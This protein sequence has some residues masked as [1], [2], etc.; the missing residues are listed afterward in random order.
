[1]DAAYE[2]MAQSGDS[3]Q[4]RDDRQAQ[5]RPAGAGPPPAQST[6]QNPKDSQTFYAEANES[7]AREENRAAGVRAAAAA[8]AKSQP[9]AHLWPSW[10][11][12]DAH[13][14]AEW[15]KSGLTRGRYPAWRA[16]YLNRRMSD[17]RQEAMKPRV[18]EDNSEQPDAKRHRR[19]DVDGDDGG[20]ESRRQPLGIQMQK[21]REASIQSPPSASA[22]IVELDS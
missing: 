17:L 22:S 6:I 21:G 14:W 1:M 20:E 11:L 8:Q 9:V 15:Q 12:G 3:R 4:E 13:Q 16:K 2:R 5:D 7:Q 19:G 10:F 18:E